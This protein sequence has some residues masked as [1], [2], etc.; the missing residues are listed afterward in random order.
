MEEEEEEEEEE[1]CAVHPRFGL[2]V[3]WEEEN[4]LCVHE[5]DSGQQGYSLW[6]QIVAWPLSLAPSC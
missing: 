2:R 4:S 3:T 1:R 5:M 6:P